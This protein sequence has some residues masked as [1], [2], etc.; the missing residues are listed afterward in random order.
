[1]ARVTAGARLHFGF[2]NL[3][4]HRP[5]LYG[6]LGVALA[7][8]Q[9]VVTAAPAT[10]VQVDGDAPRPAWAYAETACALLGVDGAAVTVE[11]ALPRH[12]GLG[13]GTQ[14][15]LAIYSAIAT[16][17]DREP[18]PRMAAPALGRGGRS[19]VG[20][21][22]FE[23]GGFVVDG[24]HPTSD[25]TPTAPPEGEWTV[26]RVTTRLAV[27]PSW[28]FVLV[29][30]T[31]EPGLAGEQED[32]SIR[33]VVERAGVAPAAAIEHTIATRL[34]PAIQ[35]G[36]HRLFADAIGAIDRLN[37]QWFATEQGG[38]QRP[39]VERIVDTLAAA[40]AVAGAGQSSWGPTV[41][42]VTTA[43]DAA[44]AKAAG[45]RAL[46]AADCAG[47]VRVVAPRNDG[48]AVERDESAPG[49]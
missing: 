40:D 39:A 28:R 6:G 34:L 42:G 36:D 30:P 22:C 14:L 35:A 21:G 16:A 19:G 41:Y 2:R 5:R 24:G 32:A 1:M 9:V 25:F 44:V 23:R 13:S 38:V 33:S 46:D 27:P 29:Q 47:M 37:G 12:T 18:A 43:A 11:R 7:E 8:P 48:A 10:T 3:A 26:P 31:I 17:H 49:I 4:L 15:A 45:E 20:V